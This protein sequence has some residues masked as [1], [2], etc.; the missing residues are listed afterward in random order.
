MTTRPIARVLLHAPLPQLDRLLDYAIPAELLSDVR[1]GVRV[2]VPLRGAGRLVDG[3]VVA[4][5]TAEDPDRPLSELD[6]VLSGV[7]VLPPTLYA[8]ARKVS[9]RAAG[10]ASDILRLVI[11]RRQVRIEKTWLTARLEADSAEPMPVEPLSPAVSELAQKVLAGFPG[12]AAGVDANARIAVDAPPRPAQTPRG[13]WVGSWATVLAAAAA[14]TLAGGRS[15]VIA[16]PDYRDLDQLEA[17]LTG[18]VPDADLV[19]DDGKRTGAQRSRA[20][21][22]MLEPRPAVVIGNRSSVYAPVTNIGLLALW[23]DGDSLFEEP[24]APYVH[25]RDAALV[26]QELEGC[27][28]ILAGHTRTADVERLVTVGWVRDLPAAR[29][30]SPRIIVS[31]TEDVAH[32]ARVSSAAFR[33]AREALERGPV[34]I[35]VARPGYAPVLT[36]AECRRPARCTH[37]GGPLHA[38]RRGAAPECRWCGRTAHSWAC[39]HCSGTTLRLASSGSARTAE[40]FGRAFAGVRIILA[41]GDHPVQRVDTHPALVIATRGAEPIADGGYQAVILLDGERML[42]AEALRIGEACLRWWSNASA[43]A[44]PGAPVHLVGVVG[45]IGRALATWNQASYARAE[46][47]ERGA[48]KLPPTVRVAA[49]EGPAATVDAAIAQLRN[50]VPTL[51]ADAVLGPIMADDAPGGDANGAGVRVLVRFDY[52]QGNAVTSSLRA[53]VIQSALRARR[54][55]KGARRSPARAPQRG[56]VA[57]T[58][59]VRV[60]VPEPEL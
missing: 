47:Q 60:D 58:L 45:T 27:A 54:P 22:R 51:A 53:A 4:L 24:L 44:A 6:T 18:L 32:A 2:R 8:L 56:A 37:C 29:R 15:A 35:Q 28:L 31:A 7:P 41:D 23:D 46:L 57:N 50:D 5:G 42:Q 52:A 19:R 38:A 25:A 16:V 21:L 26:R 1:Q 10:S 3:Y 30:Y 36:C 48:V 59:R 20:Y 13:E 9:D 17:A 49:V 34:L 39:T 14:H 43:L 12:L 11:P 55:A 40:E 33:T